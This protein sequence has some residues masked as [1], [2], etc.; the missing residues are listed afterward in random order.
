MDT[1]NIEEIEEIQYE[2]DTEYDIIIDDSDE[3]NNHIE[4]IETFKKNYS[5][6]KKK[7]ITTPNLN[8]YEM[9]RVL[10]ERTLQIE[11][12]SILYIS[13]PDSF[14]NA[15][16][17]ALEEFKQRKIPFIIRRPLPDLQGYEYWKLNDMVY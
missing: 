5:K 8:K 4:D 13:N 16:S 6:N 15:Y 14:T 1:D 3:S 2:S 7:Y 17:I 12:G 10:I 11:N 9:T